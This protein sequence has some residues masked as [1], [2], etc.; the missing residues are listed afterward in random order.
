MRQLFAL[1]ERIGPSDAP[2]LIEGPAGSGRT[3]IA[4]AIHSSSRFAAAPVTVIDFRLPPNERPTITSVGQRSD[5]FTLLLERI[6]EATPSEREALLTLY[7]RR[8]EGVLDARIIATASTDL[9]RAALDGRIRRE[10]A[11]HVAAVRVTVPSL[12]ARVDDVPLLV[13][14]F[15]REICGA[16]PT[17]RP[18][19][20]D[21]A[22]ARTYPGNVKELRQLVSLALQPEATPSSLPKAG[23]ARARAALVRPLN[24]RPKAPDPGVARERLIAY[25]ERDWLT[26]LH[27]RLGGDLAELVRE[28]GIARKELQQR[29]K[30]LGLNAR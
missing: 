22:L 2:V 29:L 7:S 3:L 21:R 6:D 24:A 9:R 4:K 11:A 20:L 15:A 25:F 16:E 27:T 19:D 28:T 14:Q 18:G 1:L 13:R 5:T 17:L 30:D 10:L 8:E 23:A 26:Q 12:A